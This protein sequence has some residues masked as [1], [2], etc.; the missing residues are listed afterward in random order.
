MPLTPPLRRVL[1]IVAL[2]NAAYQALVGAIGLL[3]PALIAALFRVGV[4]A[5][6]EAGVLRLLGALT[7]SNAVLLFVL[8]EQGEGA[9][10]LARVA[11]IGAALNLFAYAAACLSGD[12]SWQTL[13]IAIAGQVALV[14]ALALWLRSPASRS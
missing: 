11:L 14:V 5:P 1:R 4:P 7:C 9:R 13:Q 12:F 6:I 8:A 10:L 2:A 3:N